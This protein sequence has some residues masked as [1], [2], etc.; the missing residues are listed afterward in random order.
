MVAAVP[1]TLPEVE[2]SLRDAVRSLEWRQAPGPAAN[3][4][5]LSDPLAWFYNPSPPVEFGARGVDVDVAW[6]GGGRIVATG[7][8]F[9]APH[10][11][12]IAALVRAKHPGITPFELKAI[13]AAT[14]VGARSS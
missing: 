8:S 2:Q 1:Y 7:N 9:A 3:G 12:G 5:D 4:N 14:A 10:I 13:L 11:A 6:R